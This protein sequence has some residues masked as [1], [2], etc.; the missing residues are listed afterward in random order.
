MKSKKK[1]NKTIDI[2]KKN[3]FINFLLSAT[4]EDINKLI[5]EK[6]K[7]PKLIKPMFFYK[8]ENN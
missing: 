3:N 1:S 2:N 6:G 5:L 8:N 7:P 4:E